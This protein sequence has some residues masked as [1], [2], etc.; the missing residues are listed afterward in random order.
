MQEHETIAYYH[1]G[2]IKL[3][4]VNKVYTDQD[5]NKKMFSTKVE[6]HYYPDVE[7]L[8]DKIVIGRKLVEFKYVGSIIKI[9]QSKILSA[10]SIIALC[11]IYYYNRFKFKA[12]WKRKVKKKYKEAV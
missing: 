1:N 10:I 11:W 8:S 7:E 2:Q 6:N 3:G 12:E 4:D 9:F 5:T